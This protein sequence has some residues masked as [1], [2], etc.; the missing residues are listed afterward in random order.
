MLSLSSAPGLDT[1][2]RRFAPNPAT[3]PDVTVE[4]A[5]LHLYDELGT[6]QFV[7]AGVS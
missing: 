4:V 6:I 2:G 5:P 3:I 7:G 1:L